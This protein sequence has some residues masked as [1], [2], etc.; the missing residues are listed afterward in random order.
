MLKLAVFDLDGTLC[1]VGKPI[2]PETLHALHELRSRG[3]QIAVSSGKPIYYLCGTARQAG[4]ADLILMGENGASVQFGVELPPQ[5][6]YW[7]PVPEQTAAALAGLKKKLSET[8]G[9]RIWLQPTQVEVTPFF[10]PEDLALHEELRAFVRREVRE[11]MNIAVYDQRDCV[12]LCPAGIDKGSGLAY[13]CRELGI[14]TADA[15]AVG[16]GVN[17]APMLRT[18]GYSIGIGMQPVAGA[19]DSAETIGEALEK[20]LARAQ[21]S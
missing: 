18:A 3:V 21:C 16:D 19:K 15:A 5:R 7:M 2:L 20:L 13:L 14:S 1:A 4:L 8:F 10:P 9:G 6:Y 17:D 12:D 11:E